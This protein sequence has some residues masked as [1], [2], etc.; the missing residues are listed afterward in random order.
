MYGF[1]LGSSHFPGSINTVHL[2]GLLF[3]STRALVFST[4]GISFKSV[5][6]FFND[7]PKSLP[8]EQ[9]GT[10]KVSENISSVPSQHWSFLLSGRLDKFDRVT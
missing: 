5:K 10:L 4:P 8:S 9:A 7:T 6:T 1:S 3:V 2:L